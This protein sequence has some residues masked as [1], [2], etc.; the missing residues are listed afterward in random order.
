MIHIFLKK[1]N[2][3]N[4]F[5]HAIALTIR[6]VLSNNQSPILC[7]PHDEISSF[8]DPELEQTYHKFLF[9]SN[10]GPASEDVERPSKR[11]RFSALNEQNTTRNVRS[12]ILASIHSLLGFEQDNS[13][14]GLGQIPV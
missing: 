6:M 9:N 11:A 7:P 10:V 14:G 3:L 8:Q 4:A 1:I 13:Q 12:N 2:H 5:Q